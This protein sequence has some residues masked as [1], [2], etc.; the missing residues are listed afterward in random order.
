[1]AI[2]IYILVVFLALLIVFT[3]IF[4]VVIVVNILSLAITKVP[5]ISTDKKYFAKIF[6]QVRI[7]PKTVIYDL[8][9]GSGNFLLAASAF[10]PKKCVGF[11]LSPMPYFSAL[12]KSAFWGRGKMK[13]YFKDFF[14]TEIR[15]ADIVYVYLVPPL[16][17]RVALKLKHELKPGAVALAK[18]QPFPDLKYVDKIV[19]DDKSGYPLYV[20]KF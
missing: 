8:G 13:V 4:I 18:G 9:C 2:I 1:M 19:L 5:P 11:E 7:T 14:K 12:V 17:G 20:Y 3:S 6:Q 16:L 15:D 10:R